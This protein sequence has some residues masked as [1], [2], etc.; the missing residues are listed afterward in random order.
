LKGKE[1]KSKKDVPA[2][3]RAQ[4]PKAGK[5]VKSRRVWVT[6][7]PDM[8]MAGGSFRTVWDSRE[9]AEKAADKH[10]T[11]WTGLVRPITPKAPR[12]ATKGTK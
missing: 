3:R 5:K 12:R 2:K 8:S 10:R 6:F 7:C 9:M 11:V 1:M 4:A